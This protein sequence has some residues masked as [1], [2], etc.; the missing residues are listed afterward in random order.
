MQCCLVWQVHY[1][2]RM[3]DNLHDK[4]IILA[5]KSPRRQQ[6]FAGLDIEF[7]IELREVE[8]IYPDHLPFEL[9]PQFL[10]ELKAS[11]FEKT[12][13]EDEIIITADTVVLLDGLILE[14]PKSADEAKEM[15]RKLSGNTH[16]VVTGVC[17]MSKNKKETF[18]DHTRVSFAALSDKEIEFYVERYQPF[19]KA[20]S[21]GAQEW[22]GYIAIDKLEGSYFNVMGLPV[23]KIYSVLKSF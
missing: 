17:V 3:L 14:K 22:L 8:E 23:H 13:S 6:L 19:D 16:T 15:I 2:C 10:A 5:S 12:V 7:E 9:V 18:S 20:G 4:K 21:Y 11:A 1:F